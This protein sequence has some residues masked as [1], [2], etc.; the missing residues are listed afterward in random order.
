LGNART[1][2]ARAALLEGLS[3]AHP[4]ARR[5]VVAALGTFRG[6]AGVGEA[7]RE[8]L[9][10]GDP[11]YFVEGELA[12]SLGK[13]RLSGDVAHLLEAMR[14]PSFADTIAVGAIDGLAASASAD[15]FP[16]LLSLTR[17]G[18][19]PFRR[20]AA[21]AALPALAQ[22][23]DKKAEAADALEPLLRDPQF[24]VQIA[25][26][27]AAERLG[28]RRLM[29]ALEQVPFGDGRL[30]RAA[31]DAV[32]SLQESGGSA[33]EVAGLREELEQL[34]G[35]TRQLRETLEALKPSSRPAPR[36][37]VARTGRTR[38]R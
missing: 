36:K 13:L 29:G 24:R 28:E 20:R 35:E 14:R 33:R 16:A 15:A 4:K 32:R 2:S 22:L 31:R 7:L 27:D 8:R 37:R 1:P 26:V 10:K 21:V 12:R 30:R 18:E 25:A 9:R 34:K 17:Y 3:L 38:R 23:L 6:D 19:S 5:A 11:S